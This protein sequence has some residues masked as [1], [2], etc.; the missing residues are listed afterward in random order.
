MLVR[1][2]RTAPILVHQ[3]IPLATPSFFWR[4]R[5]LTTAATHDSKL[6]QAANKLIQQHDQ[7]TN[8]QTLQIKR[9]L[10]DWTQAQDLVTTLQD[11]SHNEPD[12]ELRQLAQQE[13]PEAMQ[14][15]DS[16]K[17]QLINIISQQ[18]QSSSA[19][20]QVNAAMLEIKSGVGGSE[21]NLFTAQL[22]KMYQRW[23]TRKGWKS[24]ITET[25]TPSTDV[26]GSQQAYKEVI[27]E[28]TGQ[29]AFN[30]LKREAGVHRVQRVPATESQGRVHT[31]TVSVIVLPSD[32]DSTMSDHNDDQ[33]LYNIKDVKIEVMRSRGAGGQHVNRT[34]SAVRLTHLPTGVTVSMQD[35]RSQHE[36]RTKAFKVLKARLWDRRIQQDIQERRS[37]RRKQVKGAD[38]S[39][40]VRTYNFPQ[41]RITDHRIPLT[42]S[43]LSDALDGGETLDMITRELE[44][45]EQE[46][47]LDDI[48]ET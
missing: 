15:L 8:K 25:V 5:L 7:D 32:T 35:S 24:N 23:S 3:T 18:Q 37:V 2:I 1:T 11:L 43:G 48:L 14:H 39:E 12:L 22:V 33:D 13:L 42:V 45:L 20:H 41:D 17:H 47:M 46:E 28:I 6:V 30:V 44:I 4:Q 10:Q 26:G 34:E 9:A 21:S 27:L 16:F 19:S 40:K 38:R 29:H 31:S 36:N